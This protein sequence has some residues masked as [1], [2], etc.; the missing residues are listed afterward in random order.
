MAEIEFC[1]TSPGYLRVISAGMRP[2]T[3]EN[4][5]PKSRPPR[6]VFTLQLAWVSVPHAADNNAWGWGAPDSNRKL[7][8][9]GGQ[10]YAKAAKT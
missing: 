10:V 8:I 6:Y 4:G 3:E 1:L 5:W 9:I 2:I 7:R